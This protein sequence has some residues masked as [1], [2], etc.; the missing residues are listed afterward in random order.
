MRA[1]RHRQSHLISKARP[2]KELPCGSDARRAAR[3]WR[4]G[5]FLDGHGDRAGT[6][7]RSW[8]VGTDPRHLGVDKKPGAHREGFEAERGGLGYTAQN[9]PAWVP[10]CVPQWERN[11]N[12]SHSELNRPMDKRWQMGLLKGFQ[13]EIAACTPLQRCA[14]MWGCVGSVLPLHS[15]HH[16]LPPGFS[17]D[18]PY[19]LALSCPHSF[20]YNLSRCN[21]LGWNP[22]NSAG[23]SGRRQTRSPHPPGTSLWPW[24]R[25]SSGVGAGSVPFCN[26][27]LQWTGTVWCEDCPHYPEQG[28]GRRWHHEAAPELPLLPSCPFSF[29]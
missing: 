4:C 23:V 19:S 9:L 20:H 7:G 16:S 11:A 2:C 8:D 6:E 13:Q 28:W 29:H 22:S 3:C 25:M 26:H 27:K 18:F 15:H 14:G 24:S 12:I 17:E 21:R 5:C 10:H 1:T